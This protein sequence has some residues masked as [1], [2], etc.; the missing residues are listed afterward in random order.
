MAIL[1]TIDGFMN[2]GNY[3]LTNSGNTVATVGS[4]GGGYSS[5]V[6][7]NMKKIRTSKK[8]EKGRFTWFITHFKK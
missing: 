1:P 2:L 7:K 8:K 3:K 6:K 4:G 5:K